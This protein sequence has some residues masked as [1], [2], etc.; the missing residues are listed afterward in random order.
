MFDFLRF[1]EDYNISYK[2]CNGD[3]ANINCPIPG[4][5]ERDYKGGFNLT[6][7]FYNCYRCGRHS[8]IELLQSITGFRYE[9]I[10][11]LLKEYSIGN[12]NYNN[13]SEIDYRPVKVDLPLFSKPI[14]ENEKA[15][16]YLENRNFDVYELEDKYGILATNNL[17]DVPH[18]IIIPIFFKGQLVSWTARSYLKTIDKAKRYFSASKDKEVILHKSVLYN[19]D[20]TSD[21]IVIV[22]GC[23]DVWRLG[24]SIVACFGTQFSDNQ[25][26][27]I[28]EKRKAFII[29][30]REEQAQEKARKLMNSLSLFIDVENVLIPFKNDKGEYKDPGELD[31]REVEEIRAY[32]GI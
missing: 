28:K 26:K 25:I 9:Q 24:D 22:E 30:D 31:K 20:N 18:R 13:I 3:W 7:S 27:L 19:W 32:C 29:Y 6:N 2:L 23:T 10:Y 12:T 8:K 5:K 16:K 17:S 1:C 15:F 14:R 4:C 11:T 21:I